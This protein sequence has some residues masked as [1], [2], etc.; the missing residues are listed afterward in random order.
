MCL[1]LRINE[2]VKFPMDLISARG[3]GVQ[4]ANLVSVMRFLRKEGL[5]MGGAG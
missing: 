4:S 2:K 5:A 3:V 1:S